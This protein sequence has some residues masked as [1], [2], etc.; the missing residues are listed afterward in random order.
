[1]VVLSYLSVLDNPSAMA[2]RRCSS[3]VPA[4]APGLVTITWGVSAREDEVVPADLPR[5]RG[6]RSRQR[7]VR[8]LSV[9]GAASV[10]AAAV[11]EQLPEDHRRLESSGAIQT[12]LGGD[13]SADND[14][15]FMLGAFPEA[16]CVPS[17]WPVTLLPPKP[18]AMSPNCPAL[19]P[20]AKMPHFG[21]ALLCTC[22][23]RI[24]G[25]RGHNQRAAKASS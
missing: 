3:R 21:S 18:I 19:R 9:V 12:N 15:S 6:L 16:T 8:V 7:G 5:R 25:C 4:A 20:A 10:W 11:D 22:A 24:L 17:A 2:S 1:M 23:G 13:V 14:L